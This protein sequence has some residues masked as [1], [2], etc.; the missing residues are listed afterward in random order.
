MKKVLFSLIVGIAFIAC[1]NT[2]ETAQVQTAA[3]AAPGHLTSIEWV[4]SARNL[5]KINEGQ[6]LQ[7][8]YKFKN[9]GT[10]PLVIQS[11]E[12]GCGCTVAEYPKH[13]IAPGEE[14]V[15]TGAF[16][17]RGR[18]GLQYKE[19]LVRMNTEPSGVHKLSFSV[20]VTPTQR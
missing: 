13:P 10:H 5:G 8:A 1:N 20:D 14:A 18:T 11:V 15:I 19:I 12:P 16:D 7:I 3:P 4:D 9:T 2:D 6:E 17:S